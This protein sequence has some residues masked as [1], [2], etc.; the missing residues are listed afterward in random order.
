VWS[1]VNYAS[2]GRSSK[3]TV[4]EVYSASWYGLYCL[5]IGLGMVQN[6][7][8]YSTGRWFGTFGGP[9][10][11]PA[12]CRKEA[13]LQEFASGWEGPGVSRAS[14]YLVRPSP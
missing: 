11:G 8:R 2:E 14:Q 12:W 13:K 6:V 4:P 10:Q 1:C 3:A 5:R 7:E 9:L